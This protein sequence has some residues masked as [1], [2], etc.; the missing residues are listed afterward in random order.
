MINKHTCLLCLGSNFDRHLRMRT[1]REA[2]KEFFP[3]IQFSEEMETK[4]IGDKM[5]SP[6]SNQVAQFETDFSLEEIRQL[7]KA[8]ERQNGRM[9]E[10]K[11]QGIVKLD[12][13][14]L[15]YGKQVIKPDDLQRDYVQKGLQTLT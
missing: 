5:L 10:D 1:A 8:I 9:P 15:A 7:L 11:N 13:D 14:I 4:A 3:N 6:F 2:L 12:I